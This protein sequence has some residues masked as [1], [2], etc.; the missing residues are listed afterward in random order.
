MGG[1][2][3]QKKVRRGAIV[4]FGGSGAA[5]MTPSFHGPRKHPALQTRLTIVL[6]GG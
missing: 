5:K 4:V 2:L 1:K 6:D 3:L